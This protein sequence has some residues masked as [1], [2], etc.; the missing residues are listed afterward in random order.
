MAAI[1][2][3]PGAASLS[4]ATS[5]TGAAIA[6]NSCKQASWTTVCSGVVSGGTIIIEQASSADYAGTWYLLDTIDAANASAGTEG[7]STYPGVIAFLRARISSAITGGGNVSVYLNG[8]Q[9]V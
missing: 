9:E 8:L 5:G 3:P 6:F 1:F 7:Y 2:T 4:A